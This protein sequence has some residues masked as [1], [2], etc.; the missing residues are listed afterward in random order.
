MFMKEKRQTFPSHKLCWEIIPGVCWESEPIFNSWE[1]LI[2]IRMRVM[3]TPGG[4]C[5]VCQALCHDLS[6]LTWLL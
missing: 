2:V 3:G 6:A 5:V 1:K 4:A